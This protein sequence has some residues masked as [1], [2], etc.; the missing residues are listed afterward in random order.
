MGVY[1]N[2]FFY[3]LQDVSTGVDGQEYFYSSL[4]PDWFLAKF[5]CECI[6]TLARFDTEAEVNHFRKQ[7]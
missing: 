5:L 2:N 3:S 1:E 4:Y 6:G 7:M